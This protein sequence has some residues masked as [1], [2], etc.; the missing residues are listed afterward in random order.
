MTRDQY[1][2]KYGTAPT[3]SEPIKMARDQYQKKYGDISG[4]EGK[5]RSNLTNEQFLTGTAKA[6]IPSL[7]KQAMGMAEGIVNTLNPN[8]DQ[9]TLGAAARTVQGGLQKLDPTKGK[10]IAN[11]IGDQTPIKF[12]KMAD[13]ARGMSTDYQSQAEAAGQMY[14]DRYG[15]I[16]N[17]KKSIYEDPAGVALDASMVLGGAGAGLK[18]V[19]VLTK[20]SRLAKAG[21]IASRVG[22]AIDPVSMT[23]KGIAK[24][25]NP[26]TSRIKPLLSG[27]G[28][29]L[30]V[31]AMQPSKS[32]LTTFEESTGIPFKEYIKS[33]GITGDASSALKQIQS[34]IKKSQKA[35]NSKVRTGKTINPSEYANSL[36]QQAIDILE[37]DRS[38]A[39]RSVAESLWKEAESQER[40]G[41]MSDVVLT[42][43][44]SSQFNKVP[45]GVMNDPIAANFN[46]ATGTAGIKTLEKIAPGSSAIG[47]K[48][49]KAR[50]FEDIVK[51]QANLSK[52]TQ[53]FNT[54]KPAFAGFVTGAGAGSFLPGIGNLAGGLIGAGSAA[55]INNPRVMAMLAKYMQKAGSTA[56]TTS[57]ANKLNVF[58]DLIKGAKYE[59]MINPK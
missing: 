38:P 37:S 32:Q 10:V 19:G 16:E 41:S 21:Q 46:K 35:Y 53:L 23:G 29:D 58:K 3:I 28:D 42:N 49:Q 40:M 31:R 12:V 57:K 56:K 54:V 48:L 13:K 45:G 26:I 4:E 24:V 39:A 55:T 17:I 59:R 52:G 18:G 25:T 20:S 8:I 30:A 15:G 1:N 51:N 5:Y 22:R 47:Q 14:K 34:K 50:A 11:T 27:I 6:I 7:G 33:E 44:K 36:R 43:T 2:Q 9:N